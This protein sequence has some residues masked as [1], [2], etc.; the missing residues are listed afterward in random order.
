MPE[1][2]ASQRETFIAKALDD[3]DPNVRRAATTTQQNWDTRKRAWPIELWRLWQAGERGKV[4]MS[5]LIAVTVATPV[6]ICG[7]FLIYFMARLL[8]YLQERR[9]RAIALVPVLATWATASYGMLMLYFVAGHANNPDAGE[10]AIL[11]G[12]LWGAIVAYTALGW[13]MHYAVRR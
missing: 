13:G 6:L 10:T 1:T 3:P 2:T 8:T 4:G 5:A 11:A 12:V 9:W 7:I